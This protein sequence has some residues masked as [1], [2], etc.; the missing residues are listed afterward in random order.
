MSV[1]QW[2]STLNF[3]AT[4]ISAVPLA[5]I[6]QI[7]G[8]VNFLIVTYI[9]LAVSYCLCGAITNFWF[10]LVMRFVTGALNSGAFANRNIIFVQ[11]P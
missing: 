5:N 9:L 3:I 2:L 8:Q 11:Y 4:A 6:G 10:L 1:A 7:V